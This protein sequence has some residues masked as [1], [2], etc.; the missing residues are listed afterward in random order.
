VATVTNGAGVVAVSPDVV[1]VLGAATGSIKTGV[2]ARLEAMIVPKPAKTMA[3]ATTAP[4]FHLSFASLELT[5]FTDQK[6]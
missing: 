5:S 4:S 1:V 6:P 2:G 3:N